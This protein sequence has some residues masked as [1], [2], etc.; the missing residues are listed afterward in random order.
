MDCELGET[1]YFYFKIIEY[2]LHFYNQDMLVR[3]E[4]KS[5]DTKGFMMCGN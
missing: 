1:D 2:T 4:K 3:R 5:K